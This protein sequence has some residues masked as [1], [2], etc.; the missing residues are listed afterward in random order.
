MED[1][2]DE[3]TLAA[4][5]REMFDRLVSDLIEQLPMHFI[6]EDDTT[7]FIAKKLCLVLPED[8]QDRNA[9]I[10]DVLNAEQM[11]SG[12]RK[13]VML[14]IVSAL[15]RRYEYEETEIFEDME[16]DDYTE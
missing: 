9:I 8:A 12:E 13:K 2:V 5:P 10:V 1:I 14:K 7:T 11:Q 15:E 4:N 16:D 6:L 3:S